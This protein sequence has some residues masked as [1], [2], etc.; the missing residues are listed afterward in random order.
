MTFEQI[1][2]SKTNRFVMIGLFLAL[3]ELIRERLVWVKQPKSSKQLHLR[4]L[5]DEPAEQAVQKAIQAS[6]AES[7]DT[8]TLKQTRPQEKTPVPITEI[9]QKTGL[10]KSKPPVTQQQQQSAVPI[11]ELPPENKPKSKE[12]II[13]Q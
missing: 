12:P 11:T 8:E 4:S 9:S 7:A 3:L 10:A 6:E 5:T 2:E 13:D 1:F